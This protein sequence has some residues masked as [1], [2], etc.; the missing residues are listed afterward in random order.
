[1]ISIR[2]QTIASFIPPAKRIADVG[3]DH[4]YVIIEAFQKYQIESAV[5]L[6]N[7]TGPLSKAI[8]NIRGFD[9]FDRIN[10]VLSEGLDQFYAK[11]DAFIFAGMGGL[12]I[13]D[14][15]KN[16]LS[17]IGDAKLII[18]A[19]SHMADVRLF[20]NDLGFM[21]KNEEI[22]FEGGKYYELASFEKGEFRKYSEEEIFFGPLLLKRKNELFLNKIRNDLRIYQAIPKKTL[23][24]QKLI[25]KI[26]DL[27]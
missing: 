4:G 16:G 1:M 17:K 9:F 23:K 14:I 25:N 21:I 2:L 19:N 3:C 11:V 13:I 12:T 24:I 5:A 20:L 15:I 27:L 7:K 10:F 8:D 6:D 18:Q 22:V 26:E